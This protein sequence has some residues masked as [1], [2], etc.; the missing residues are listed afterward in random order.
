MGKPGDLH[1]FRED[2]GSCL[3]DGVSGIERSEFRKS[4]STGLFLVVG[5]DDIQGFRGVKQ[6]KHLLIVHRNRLDVDARDVL[7][8][9]HGRRIDV[10]ED[11]EFQEVIREVMIFEMGR[12]PGGILVVGVILDR[13]DIFDLHVIRQYD[14]TAGMLAG[15]ALDAFAAGGQT[16][17][18][19]S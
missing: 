9:P 3:F 17:A 6:R 1:Q 4:G 19:S 18:L 7:K 8:E 12:T 11:I 14:D 5:I 16:L 15:G 10:T 2:V 13:R